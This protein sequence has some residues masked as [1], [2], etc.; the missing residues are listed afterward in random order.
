MHL[1]EIE[2]KYKLIKLGGKI[3]KRLQTTDSRFFF[4]G[5]GGGGGW[6]GFDI[7]LGCC[8]QTTNPTN[9]TQ[10]N[11]NH[12]NTLGWFFYFHGLM[13]WVGLR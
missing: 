2:S 1:L 8:N 6:G 10:C 3:G 12:P 4:G 5:G 7:C 9:Q 13:G 11:P